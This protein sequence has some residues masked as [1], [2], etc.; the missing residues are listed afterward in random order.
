MEDD[1]V[2]IHK[3]FQFAKGNQIQ[4]LELD[5][6]RFYDKKKLKCDISQKISTRIGM[7][8]EL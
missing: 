1:F 7:S 6:S 8:E 5:F 4:I 3:Q 2:Q